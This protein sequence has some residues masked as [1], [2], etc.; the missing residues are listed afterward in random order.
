[1]VNVVKEIFYSLFDE[2]NVKHHA[3][4]YYYRKKIPKIFWKF[5]SLTIYPEY[6][7]SSELLN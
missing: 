6:L 1:M 4:S 7:S 3:K 2:K 5:T